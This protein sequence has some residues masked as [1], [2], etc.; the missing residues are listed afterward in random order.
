APAVGRPQDDQER[1]ELLRAARPEGTW[2]HGTARRAPVVPAVAVPRTDE[3]HARRAD[4]LRTDARALAPP[5]RE[6]G[7]RAAGRLGRGRVRETVP[8]SDE[9]RPR[10]AGDHG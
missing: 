7:G 1:T 5:H 10:H 2:A 9:R 6:L 4:G 3:L 8:G